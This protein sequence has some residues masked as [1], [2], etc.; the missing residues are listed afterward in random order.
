ME[1]TGKVI[2]ILPEQSGE[3]RNGTWR[4]QEFILEV[5][6]Q[7]P[8][9]V[10]IAMWGDKIDQVALKAGEEV[11]ASIDIESREYNGKWFTSVKAWKV[12][13]VQASASAA[14]PSDFPPPGEPPMEPYESQDDLPF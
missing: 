12:D 1:L 11:T 9:K 14:E 4:R 13:K 6:G 10:C 5:P 2:E 8:R 3:G 7:Y